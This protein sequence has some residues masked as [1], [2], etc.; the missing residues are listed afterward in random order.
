MALFG[1]RRKASVERSVVF[2]VGKNA[3]TKKEG[4]TQ[5]SLNKN[6]QPFDSLKNKGIYQEDTQERESLAHIRQLC[7]DYAKYHDL[8]PMIITIYAQFPLQGMRIKARTEKETELFEEQFFEK[9]DYESYLV[10]VGR[11]FFKVGEVNSFAIFDYE[12]NEWVSEEILNPDTV[13]VEDSIFAG[14]E[15]VSIELPDY[16]TNVMKNFSHP[17]HDYLIDTYPD[18]V[19]AANENNHVRIKNEFIFR[20][21]DK[22]EPWDLYGTPIMTRAFDALLREES[23]NAAQDAVAD[24][25]YSPLIL[26][27]LGIPANDMGRDSEPWIPTQA[28]LDNFTETFD[29]ALAADFRAIIHHMGIDIKSVFG[30]ESMPNMDRDFERVE[31]KI[32]RAFGI[33]QGLLDGSS[34]GA[35]ASS[36]INRDFVSQMMAMYQR[37]VRA[38]FKKRA[39]VFAR[40]RKI[41]ETET[42]RDGEDR[43]KTR[44]VYRIDE[45]GNINEEQEPIVF[46]PELEF[47]T[48]PLKDSSFEVNLLK[49]LN[50]LGVPISKQ[51]FAEAS[52]KELDLDLERSRVQDETV[53]EALADKARESAVAKALERLELDSSPEAA[54]ETRENLEKYAP[55]VDADSVDEV[56]QE[57][58]TYKPSDEGIS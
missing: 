1:R 34:N 15:Q 51:T 31:K 36:A 37:N 45:D 5:I 39:E 19:D 30:R 35:Y 6:R 49:T 33:G 46:V 13:H 9:L 4:N 48:D 23:L 29:Q 53:A 55:E 24:R 28:Q 17:E 58:N 54:E 52:G 56:E 41:Y 47:A 38:L 40:E 10:D 42:G 44:T 11:E 14:E 18:I 3:S 2:P 12:T 22:A 21:V 25:L 20:M 16:L 27:K 43:V 26:A 8:I 7:R 50:G 57:T 32:M